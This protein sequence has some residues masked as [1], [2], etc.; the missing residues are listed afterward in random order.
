MQVEVSVMAGK[1]SLTLIGQN[2]EVMQESAQAALTYSRAHAGREG[3]RH[4]R[5]GAPCRAVWHMLSVSPNEV[6]A[7]VHWR[8]ERVEW[9]P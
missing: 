5:R 4:C 7:D 8:V 2:G 1:G 6:N 3:N 9:A